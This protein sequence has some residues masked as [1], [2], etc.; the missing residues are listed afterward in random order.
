MNKTYSVVIPVYKPDYKFEMLI[1]RLAKQKIKPSDMILM[2]T[3]EKNDEVEKIEQRLRSLFS[4][5]K[6]PGNA[7]INIKI[8]PVNK[9]EFDHG[10]TRNLGAGSTESDYILFMTQDAVPCDL[11]LTEKLLES[12]DDNDVVIT[13]ARQVA[14]GSAS[15]IEKITRNY[16]YPNESKTKNIDNLNELG[17]KTYFCSDVC[18]MYDKRV[19]FMQGGFTENLIFNED[20]IYAAGI[21]NDGYSIYYNADAKVYHSHKYSLIQQFK[22]N[23]DLGVSQ[24]QYSNIFAKV[25]SEHSGIDF[26]V[27]T[28]KELILC[29]NYAAV[30]YLCIES[31][32]KYCGYVAGKCYM[33]LPKKLIMQCTMNKTYWEK[34]NG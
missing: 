15:D 30:I 25:S 32:F 31:A 33:V 2:V 14:T 3:N 18:A 1:E 19:F 27:K 28:A 6:I 20:M 8:I 21:I 13:Y 23:F 5:H 26:V 12:F 16:N 11:Y 24:K 29:K 10:G 34:K 17:I 9:I 7:N 4:I 22:R